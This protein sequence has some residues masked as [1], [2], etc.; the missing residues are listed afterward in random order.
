MV[1]TATY[2]LPRVVCDVYGRN[3]RV[4]V[5]IGEH[6]AP[7]EPRKD[8]RPS[9][10]AEVR[11]ATAAEVLG[12]AQL[13]ASFAAHAGSEAD[14]RGR[15]SRDVT[16]A[17]RALLVAVANGHVVGYAR[18]GWVQSDAPAPDGVYLTGLIV[19]KPNRR[20]GVAAA[21]ISLAVAR[22]T[23]E[24]DAL[25]SFYDVENGASAALHDSLG[26]REVARGHIGFPGLSPDSQD[27]LVQLALPRS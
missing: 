8:P 11:V 5:N 18:L 16:E 23:A 13:A 14:W 21:L 19:D 25:W 2:G 6:F 12:A 15:L 10:D 27:V 20:R 7:V 9:L 22:A 1:T 24:A 3:Y 26:F 17:D 4:R